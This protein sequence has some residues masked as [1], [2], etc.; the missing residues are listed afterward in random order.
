MQPAAVLIATLISDSDPA[1][2]RTSLNGSESRM[3]CLVF[4]A[5]LQH[6]PGA[7]LETTILI[8]CFAVILG[9]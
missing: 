5:P 8:I 3:M 6:F 1:L 9:S 7:I 2:L 4:C